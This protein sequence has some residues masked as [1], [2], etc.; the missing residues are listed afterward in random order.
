M[1]EFNSFITMR[2]MLFIASA[3][4]YRQFQ[5]E[6]RQREWMRKFRYGR[7]RNTCKI[8]F[9]GLLI[10]VFVYDGCWQ[11]LSP[12]AILFRLLSVSTLWDF[13]PSP[14]RLLSK[15]NLSGVVYTFINGIDKPIKG[16][17]KFEDYLL[18]SYLSEDLTEDGKLA[19]VEMKKRRIEKDKGKAKYARKKQRAN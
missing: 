13:F 4:V 9:A 10:L 17:G 5:S 3:G 12:L 7:K 6:Q 8:V 18:K 14:P 16:I 11:P 19:L 15:C 1:R 2:S